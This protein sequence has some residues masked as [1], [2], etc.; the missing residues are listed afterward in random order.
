MQGAA[1]ARCMIRVRI[2]CRKFFSE[3]ATEF[4]LD[5]GGVLE[6]Y[7]SRHVALRFDVGDTVIRF[8]NL[9]FTSHN[10]QIT[11]GVAFRF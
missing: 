10:L 4:A 6:L 5:Y 11:P 2:D 9:G 1:L 7:P 3:R 8:G